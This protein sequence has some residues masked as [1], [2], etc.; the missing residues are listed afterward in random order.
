MLVIGGQYDGEACAQHFYGKLRTL[1]YTEAWSQEYE[2]LYGKIKR[3]YNF[4]FSL[5][6]SSTTIISSVGR[7]LERSLNIL[8]ILILH[9]L[10]LSPR[11]LEGAVNSKSPLC[12]FCPFFCE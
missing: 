8:I 4:A 9:V 2:K 5:T 6:S 7:S 3:F 11:N 10:E 12:S 1:C